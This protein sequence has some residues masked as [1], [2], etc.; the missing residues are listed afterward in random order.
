MFQRDIDTTTQ[1]LYHELD[2][3]VSDMKQ[4]GLKLP[5][6][7]GIDD[8]LGVNIER[9][10]DGTFHLTQPHL[11]DTILKEM[12]LHSDNVSVKTTPAAVS[13]ILKRDSDGIAFDG[14][15]NYRSIIGK[16]NFLEKNTRPDICDF[17]LSTIVCRRSRLH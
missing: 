4:I 6:E 15:F 5:I 1:L 9:R 16:L 2:A 7:G 17:K 3:I 10:D 13:A 8:F 14:H 11:I 12:R